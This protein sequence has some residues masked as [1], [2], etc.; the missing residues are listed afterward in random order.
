MSP[1]AVDGVKKPYETALYQEVLIKWLAAFTQAKSRGSIGSPLFSYVYH[2]LFFLDESSSSRNPMRTS[3]L[4]LATPVRPVGAER[5]S[6]PER[7]PAGVADR[8]GAGRQQVEHDVERAHRTRVGRLQQRQR[9]W[10]ALRP[11]HRLQ[12]ALLEPRKREHDPRSL[13]TGA[14]HV[15]FPT[16]ITQPTMHCRLRVAGLP[17]PVQPLRRHEARDCRLQGL[18]PRKTRAMFSSKQQALQAVIDR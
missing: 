12:G 14:R 11:Q 7:R 10:R 18:V 13:Q 3:M 17:L 16:N 5:E 4:Q 1:P 6:Q 2:E 9:K 15:T 8:R